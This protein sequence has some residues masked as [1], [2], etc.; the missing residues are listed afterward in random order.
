MH[1]SF[2]VKALTAS[3]RSRWRSIWGRTAGS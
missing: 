2:Y 1:N 3:A